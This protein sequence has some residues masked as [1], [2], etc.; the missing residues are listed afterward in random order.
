MELLAD[1]VPLIFRPDHEQ[2]NFAVFSTGVNFGSNK[3][4]NLTILL[5]NQMVTC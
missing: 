2:G 5:G 3:S 1:S 4:D